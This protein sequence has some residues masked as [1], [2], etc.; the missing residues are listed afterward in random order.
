MDKN[1]KKCPI[2]PIR[3]G[4]KIENNGLDIKNIRSEIVNTPPSD[5]A[6]ITKSSE[7][8]DLLEKYEENFDYCCEK[9]EKANIIQN[10]EL[11]LIDGTTRKYANWGEIADN[12]DEKTLDA[13]RNLEN[14]MVIPD[15]TP[16]SL[17]NIHNKFVARADFSLTD[18]A[19]SNCTTFKDNKNDTKKLTKQ[20]RIDNGEFG[21][22]KLG[23]VFIDGEE[24]VPESTLNLNAYFFSHLCQKQGFNLT[25]FEIYHALQV[26]GYSKFPIGS[27]FTGYENRNYDRETST[28]LNV[29][30]PE[31]GLTACST[32]SQDFNELNFNQFNPSI[33]CP[34]YG[35]RRSLRVLPKV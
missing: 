1:D 15:I 22:S 14:P 17:K 9:L 19:M 6:I 28:W 21:T 25:D 30:F 34:D 16:G 24:E 5:P 31:N 8:C 3:P 11:A 26:V 35:G 20:E 13:I 33:P 2:I 10:G 12:I 32:W 27:G 7:N 18:D 23:V 4:I 29:T